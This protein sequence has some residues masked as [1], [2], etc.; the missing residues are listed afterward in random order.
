LTGG[1]LH[2]NKHQSKFIGHMTKASS[3]V[4]SPVGTTHP[5]LSTTTQTWMSIKPTKLK[6]ASSTL[7][8]LK[9]ESSTRSAASFLHGAKTIINMMVV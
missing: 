1:Q 3:S 2:L 8:K 9:R 4:T 6:L 7:C 5:Q